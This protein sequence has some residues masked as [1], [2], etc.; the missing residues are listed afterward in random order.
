MELIGLPG[1]I[2]GMAAECWEVSED[3]LTWTFTVLAT[4]LFGDGLRDAVD[5]TLK[6]Q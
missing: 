4:T 1:D 3:G 2:H 6:G 5:P